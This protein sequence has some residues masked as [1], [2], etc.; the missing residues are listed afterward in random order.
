METEWNN[1]YVIATKKYDSLRTITNTE[2]DA[3]RSILEVMKKDREKLMTRI[4]QQQGILRTPRL[5]SKYREKYETAQRN[6]E[7]GLP[8][9]KDE[10]EKIDPEVLKNN[11]TL[12]NLF[13]QDMSTRGLTSPTSAKT[14]GRRMSTPNV[15]NTHVILSVSGKRPLFERPITQSALSG[16]DI[17]EGEPP[18]RDWQQPSFM[19]GQGPSGMGSPKFLTSQADNAHASRRFATTTSLFTGNASTRSVS[20]QGGI[21]NRRKSHGPGGTAL[22]VY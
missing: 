22:R 8:V 11:I 18:D 9:V 14:V 1:K 19:I 12:S 2:F 21:R 6:M 10:S 16:T 13:T 17:T 3:N 7:L 5:Y 20:A 4:K 15:G